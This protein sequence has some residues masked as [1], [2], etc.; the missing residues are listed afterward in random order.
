MRRQ[1]QLKGTPENILLVLRTS[2]SERYETEQPCISVRPQKFGF[3][4]VHL[5]PTLI[6]TLVPFLLLAQTA[7]SSLLNLPSCC[8]Q[9]EQIREKRLQIKLLFFFKPCFVHNCPRILFF[10]PCLC[11]RRPR[12]LRVCWSLSCRAPL[13]TSRPWGFTSSCASARLC[14]TPKTTSA[15]PSR[16]PW[17]SSGWTPTLAKF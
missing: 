8:C 11:W 16:W 15:S 12:V 10:A 5:K 7:A 13:L 14:T 9:V 6:T 2:C 17:P 3:G 1:Q 4:F